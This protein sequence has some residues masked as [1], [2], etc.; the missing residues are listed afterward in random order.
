MLSAGSYSWGRSFLVFLALGFLPGGA[1]AQGAAGGRAGPGASLNRDSVSATGR[2][3]AILSVS[4]FGRY[5]VTVT[6][7]QGTALQLVDRMAGPG[8]LRGEAGKQDGRLDGFL[9]GGEYKVVAFSGVKGTGKARLAAHPFEEKNPAPP[10]L[11]ELKPVEGTLDDFEQVSYWLEVKQRRRVVIEAAGRNLADLRLWSNGNWLVDASPATEVV[12]P[13]HGQLLLACRL[14]ADLEPGYYLLSAYGGAPQPWAEDS[15]E[16]PFHLRFGISRLPTVGRQRFTVSP[17]GID[18]WVLPGKATYLR[19]ELPEARPASLSAGVYDERRPFDAEGW[20]VSVSKN[21]LVPVAETEMRQTN[22]DRVVTVTAEAGQPYVLQHFDLGQPFWVGGRF[23]SLERGGK[24]WV[25]T[26]HSGDPQDSIDATAIVTRV[27]LRNADWTHQEPFLAQVIEL[28]PERS[29][30]RRCNLLDPMTLFLHVPK[31]GKYELR[32]RGSAARFRIEPFLTYQLEHYEVPPF[33]ESGGTWDLDAGYYVL[34]AEP[35]K[36]GIVDLAIR[37]ADSP[38]VGDPFQQLAGKGSPAGQSIQTAVQFLEVQ[39]DT[40]HA[41]TVYLN[42][43][44]GVRAGLVLRRFPVDLV[45]PLPVIHPPGQ[46]LSIPVRVPEAGTLNAAAEDDSQVEISVDGGGWERSPSVSMGEHKVA[47]RTGGDRPARYALAAEPARL[48]ASAPLPPLPDTAQVVPPDFPVLM[49]KT[50]LFL[51][52]DRRSQ[53]TF[54][55][56]AD[57]PALY[58]LESS[59]LLATEGNLRTRTIPRFEASAENGVGRNF[60]LD[61]YLRAGEY[62]LT[63]TTR[64]ETKGHLGVTLHQ[65]DFIDGGALSEGIPARIALRAGEGVAYR[66]TIAKEGEYRLRAMG[67]GTIF[68]CRLEDADGWPIERPNIPASLTRH[69]EPGT[70]RLV[71]LPELV[72]SRRVTLLQAV[73]APLRFKG[74]GPYPLPLAQQVENVWMEPNGEDERV[75]DTWEFTLPAP[76]DATI[77]LTGEMQGALQL[78]DS[79]GAISD[80]ATVS[81]G[82]GW[83]GKLTAG[84]HLLKVV[85]SRRNNRQ[86]YHV[87]VWPEQLVAGLTR[88]VHA[89]ARLP[90]SLGSDGLVDIAS[91]GS[92][93]VRGRL[94]DA[95]GHLVASN[96]D[97]AG[98]WNFSIQRRLA[99]GAYR[100]DVEPVG[101]AE[102]DTSISIRAPAEV[103]GQPLSLPVQTVLDLEQA[104]RLYPVTVPDGAELFVAT[105]RSAEGAGCALEASSDGN[106]RT[107]AS[108]TGPVARVEVPLATAKQ[109]SGSLRYRL[110]IWSLDG[111]SSAVRLNAVAM[112][113]RHIDEQQIEIGL[114]ATAIPGIDPPAAVA[115]VDLTR[116]GVFRLPSDL[117]DARWSPQEEA[118]TRAAGN[119]LLSAT[120]PVLWL[121]RDVPT[122]DRDVRIQTLRAFVPSD[123]EAGLQF[124][125]QPDVPAIADLTRTDAG[126]VLALA[127]SAGKP[128]GL[129]FLEQERSKE[130][131]TTGKEM[132]PGPSSAVAAF[133]GSRPVAAVLWSAGESGEPIDVRLQQWNFAPAAEEEAPWGAWQGDVEGVAARA[134]DLAPGPKRMKLVLGANLVGVLSQGS[135]VE[136][137]HWAE[138]EPFEEA[139]ETTAARLTLLHTAKGTDR[140]H[141]Q[142]LA[143]EPS[144][145][146]PALAPGKPYERSQLDTGTV[147]LAVAAPVYD[148]ERPFVVHVRGAEGEAVLVGEDGRVARG[149]DIPIRPLSPGGGAPGGTL[150]VPHASGLVLAWLDRR[151]E[152]AQDLWGTGAPPAVI[153]V[154]APAVVTLRGAALALDVPSR[155]PMM[156]HVRSATAMVTLFQPETGAPEVQVHPSGTLLDAYVDSATARLGLRAIGGGAL[157]GSVEITTSPVTPIR[158]GL[159][160]EV[161]LP[162]GAT[163]LF[164]FSVAHEGSVGVGVRAVPDVASCTLLDHAGRRLGSGVVQMPKLEPG[165]YLLEVQVPPDAGP[166]RVRPALAGVELPGT[167]PPAEVVRRYMEM[168]GAEILR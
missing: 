154:E 92:A 149:A 48:Q 147:R 10:L 17:F 66:F 72:E 61:Q 151:G 62:Q 123:E 131:V 87:A 67:V 159:G 138:G 82:R 24:F 20:Q 38:T 163:R 167:G 49:D 63:V 22:S 34:T 95:N 85:C 42:Q 148:P 130:A 83:K 46:T 139:L 101:A 21:S 81:P 107:I 50:P 102:G 36:A 70:Y 143:I 76:V 69:F 33:Q 35:V 108:A 141:V 2:Q 26:V 9:D 116:A 16:H 84:R 58:R 165:T 5:A 64:G 121:F 39:F 132:A 44:P 18:R 145:V 110:R 88:E 1:G 155:E 6:S 91:F 99:P 112:A 73:P 134:Y 106:W 53:A 94:L 54:L 60:S 80:I 12:E 137:V 114:T 129:R 118:P 146:T 29:W 28:D 56:R 164:S 97:R 71:L 127:R 140:F 136:S 3:E 150:L 37:A 119:G 120:G 142:A 156:L 23:W 32:S 15:G 153:K 51:D 78:V 4:R 19:L 93:D 160:D 157:G 122:A 103:E 104:V 109:A 113:P 128:V 75:P 30:A 55:V 74:H 8:E 13:V 152:E 133:L 27:D 41:Y 31:L 168:A 14:S 59:G 25:S 7:P 126:P 144:Q 43:Q 11:V 79:D 68:R 162:A 77:E 158:E 166:A 98:D 117:L 115:A 86:P 52:L 45:E 111:G 96:D 161:L 57:H 65:A 125:L 100:L 47:L 89:P 90:V 105:A 135:Q 124:A 40:N